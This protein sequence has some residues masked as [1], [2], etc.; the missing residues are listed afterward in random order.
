MKKRR[1]SGVMKGRGFT[2]RFVSPVIR[3]LWTLAGLSLGWKR[4]TWGYSRRKSRTMGD[5][6]WEEKKKEKESGKLASRG[7]EKGQL[8]GRGIEL[9][10][11]IVWTSGCLLLWIKS[12]RSAKSS[13]KPWK[14]VY[15][16]LFALFL[17][18][19]TRLCSPLFSLLK[20]T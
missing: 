9:T 18:L 1:V 2:P 19:C 6:E 17:L 4:A 3:L 14:L 20:Y 5:W 11:E 13:W 15:L 12:S 10:S 7:E 16:P 8:E